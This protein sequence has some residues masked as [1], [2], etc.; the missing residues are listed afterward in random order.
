MLPPGI[1]DVAY[2]VS[3]QLHASSGDPAYPSIVR[4]VPNE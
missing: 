3:S 2:I 4:L 1:I